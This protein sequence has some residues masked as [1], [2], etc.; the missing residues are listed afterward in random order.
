M[1]NTG[2]QYICSACSP[3][4]KVL[5]I[6]ECIQLVDNNIMGIVLACQKLELLAIGDLN[7]LS[8][9]IIK[10]INEYNGAVNLNSIILAG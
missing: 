5:D 8:V 7:K 1:S 10:W 3:S 4:L 2:L 6:S 9:E